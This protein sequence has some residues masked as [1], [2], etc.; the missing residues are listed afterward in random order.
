MKQGNKKEGKNVVSSN[1]TLFFFKWN[2]SPTTPRFCRGGE[3]LE[4]GSEK[5]VIAGVFFCVIIRCQYSSRSLHIR[6]ACNQT[7]RRSNGRKSLDC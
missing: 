7:P 5:F 1:D 3:S 6:L 2:P 4:I